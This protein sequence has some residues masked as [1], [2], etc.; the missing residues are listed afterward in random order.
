MN[1]GP[2]QQELVT[3]LEA[4]C[5]D[6]LDEK[7]W[8]R[9]EEILLADPEA[10]A[11]Y[12]RYINSHI[13]L[14]QYLAVQP[15]TPPVTTGS[16]APSAFGW[17]GHSAQYLG[18]LCWH[19]LP[20]SILA[21]IGLPLICVL[22]VIINV[23]QPEV[24]QIKPTPGT[25]Q[26]DSSKMAVL[27]NTD[28]CRWDSASSEPTV[29]EVFEIGRRISLVEGLAEIKMNS[30]T[31]VILEGPATLAF[32]AGGRVALDTGKLTAH[33]PRRARGF[34]VC[35]PN[36]TVTDLGTEFG[37]YVEN[38]SGTADIEVFQG[39][40]EFEPDKR[41]KAKTQPAR[42]ELSAG[43]AV[44]VEPTGAN[45]LLAVRNIS[46]STNF[47]VR[48]MPKRSTPAI[49]A[50]FSGGNGVSK[51]DQYPG[52][53]GLGWDS[54]WHIDQAEGIDCKVFV[55]NTN[56]LLGGGDYLRMVA[57]RKAGSDHVRRSLFRQ[58][59]IND[60]INLKKPYV[61][62][63]DVR[64]DE[65]SQFDNPLN[66]VTICNNNKTHRE[67]TPEPSGGWLIRV[68]GTSD[69][70]KY[71]KFFNRIGDHHVRMVNSN[72]PVN[73][74]TVYSFRLFVY[75]K[76]KGWAPAISVNSGPFMQFE[77]MG[78]RSHGTAIQREYWPYL[79]FRWDMDVPKNG[80]ANQKCSLSIDSI[81]VMS[82]DDFH[83]MS[84]KTQEQINM[85]KTNPIVPS[86]SLHQ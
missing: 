45:G 76:T 79:H 66:V 55:E 37:V 3:L 42:R 61:I 1:L 67:L 81:K 22:L 74:G 33:V 70:A 43:R 23:Y 71:W 12:R 8:K 86:G 51:V 28:N 14:K 41:K 16:P 29:G 80:Q 36:V 44:R 27:S 10:R 47:F 2:E 38:K 18:S 21:A 50:D 6:S 65:L 46:T 11:F 63:F 49:V 26:A 59:D 15:P 17:I 53:A 31:T 39:K 62:S 82:L 5:C 60:P 35:T 32:D 72:V 48:Q 77:K 30:G 56:P 34:R 83:K 7:G 57:E 78:M 24:A 73:E 20:F 69:G 68:N 4:V 54:D 64:I 85:D 52:T 58:L 13:G 25:I 9:L 19:A 40:V 75:P 84:S